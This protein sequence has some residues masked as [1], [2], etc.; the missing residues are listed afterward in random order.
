[1]GSLSWASFNTE[2]NYDFVNVYD[3]SSEGSPQMA[4]LSGSHIPDTQDATQR[5]MTVVFTSDSSEESDGFEAHYGCVSETGGRLAQRW[6]NLIFLETLATCRCGWLSICG[7]WRMR[8]ATI[9]R[10]RH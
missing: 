8:R 7:R 2:S 1:M 4:Q 10:Y 5:Y 6:A 9:L 3:G